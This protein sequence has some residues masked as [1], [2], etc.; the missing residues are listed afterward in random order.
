MAA[1][2]VQFGAHSD[3]AGGRA[4]GRVEHVLSG[5][6]AHFASVADLLAFISRILAEAPPR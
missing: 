6:T 4:G 1:F 3:P 5:R 2:V